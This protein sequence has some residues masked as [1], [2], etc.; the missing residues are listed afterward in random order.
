[1]TIN[2]YHIYA[3]IGLRIRPILIYLFDGNRYHIY[4]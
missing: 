4:V 1:M 3:Y 2:R